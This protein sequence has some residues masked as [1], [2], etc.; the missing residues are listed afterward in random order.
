MKQGTR[1]ASFLQVSLA[2]LSLVTLANAQAESPLEKLPYSASML[3]ARAM[4]A[5]R[6]RPQPA[7]VP[8]L[9]ASVLTCSPGPCIM[10][11]SQASPVD[12]AN[13]VNT[14]PIVSNPKNSSILMSG[15]NDYNCS[16][17]LGFYITTNTGATWN[18]TCMGTA[19]GASSGVGGPGVAFDTHGVAYISG[20]EAL[21]TGATEIVLETSAN[22][23]VTWSAAQVAVTPLF[24]GGLSD[25]GWLQIDTMASSPHVNC[26]YIS[27]T[28]LDTS[29]DSTIAVAHSCNGGTTWTNVQVDS[30]QISPLTVDQFSN[31][32]IANN[33][34]VYVSWMRCPETGKAGDCGGTSANMLIANS[35]DGGNTWSAPVVMAKVLLAPDTCGGFFG[36]V[37]NTMEP[38]SNIPVIGVDNSGNIHAGNIYAVMYTYS[39]RA[40]QLQVQVVTSTTGGATWSKPV[41]VAPFG[42]NDEFFPWLAVNSSSGKIGATW[43]DRRNDPANVSYQAFVATCHNGG[44]LFGAEGTVDTSGTAV[45]SKTG[46]QFGD[47]IGGDTIEINGIYYTIST[48]NS[49]ASLTLTTS[50]GTQTNASYLAAANS[51]LI[52]N[53][54]NPN[55]DGFGG[56]FMGDYTGNFFWGHSFFVSWM[57]SSNGSTMVDMA[58]GYILPPLT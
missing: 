44:E 7:N 27:T 9:G 8:D 46:D 14:D 5:G 47:L 1:T 50:A 11:T 29:N 37:P 18:H 38:L 52:S 2:V 36:C 55:N 58:G 33:G 43:L 45:T 10:P 34:T 32:T 15:G 31:L 17:N 19:P 16:T 12:D 39:T 6:L 25:Q 30:L 3:V 51:A 4:Q 22:D 49:S 41:R 26:I 35:K 54:S 42:T 53:L 23:G 48:V 40:R 28:Q 24:T 20:V 21:A 13:P 56:V 57:D